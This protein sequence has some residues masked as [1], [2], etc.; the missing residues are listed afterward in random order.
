MTQ[1]PLSPE[2]RRAAG[3]IARELPKHPSELYGKAYRLARKAGHS[4]TDA[5]SMATVAEYASVNNASPFM[6]DMLINMKE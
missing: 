5:S 2:A 4:P 6:T 1:P 3:E